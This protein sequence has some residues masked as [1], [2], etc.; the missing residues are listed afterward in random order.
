MSFMHTFTFCIEIGSIHVHE[1]MTTETFLHVL[2]ITSFF[3]LHQ[4]LLSYAGYVNEKPF[5]T[6]T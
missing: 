1:S 3:L 2:I 4:I 5:I 6:A